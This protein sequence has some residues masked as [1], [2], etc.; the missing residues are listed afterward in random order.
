MGLGNP[1]QTYEKTP[2]N[3]GF[4]V[5][6]ALKTAYA[7][8]EKWR[9][10]YA[11]HIV[12]TTIENRDVMLVKPLTFMNNSGSA[13]VQIKKYHPVAL[14]DMWLIHDE[15]DLPFGRVKVVKGGS[16]AGHKGVQSIIDALG[17]NEFWRVR[18]GVRPDPY[19]TQ[20][21]EI[22]RYLT[23]TPLADDVARKTSHAAANLVSKLLKEGIAT[24]DITFIV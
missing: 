1:G 3:L 2:H 14:E 22:D 10:Q 12:K 13:L 15:L 6:D 17:N 18:I 21:D 5:V 11:S 20:K 19:T 23:Q 16:S 4:R 9:E 7:P 8:D 24:K